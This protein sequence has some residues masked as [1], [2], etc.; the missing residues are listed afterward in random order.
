ME[1]RDI[2]LQQVVPA[3]NLRSEGTDLSELQASIGEHGVLQ[4][5]RVRPIGQRRFQIIAGHRRFAACRALGVETIPAV[6]VEESDERAAVQTIVENLQRED[7]TPIDLTRGIKELQTS[8]G[9]NPDEIGAAISKSPVQVRNYL[10]IA[11]LPDTVLEHLESGEGRTQAVRGLTPRHIQPLI[12]DVPV[13]GADEYDADVRARVAEATTTIRQLRT[14]L[15][16]RGVRINAHMADAIGRNVR[17]GRMTIPD[18]VDEVLANPEKYR[19]TKPTSTAEELERDTWGAYRSLQRELGSVA[20]KLRPEI[21]MAFSPA[22]R[23]DLLEQLE[24]LLARIE[25][26]RAA[27]LRGGTGDTQVMPLT[28]G[29]SRGNERD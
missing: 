15:E 29:R 9:M 8:F 28:E 23:R 4:P 17:S 26:Y 3:R 10:R 7:L 22:Q 19:Y 2:P 5:I 11:R 24:P 27:L 16:T 14:E 12:V 18:A 25:Q 21:A 20:Y 1:V 6:I 13:T